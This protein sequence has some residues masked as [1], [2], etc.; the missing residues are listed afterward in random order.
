MFDTPQDRPRLMNHL[1]NPC[2]ITRDTRT[3]R[4][5]CLPYFHVL[6]A[7][8]CGTTDFHSRLVK[9]PDILNN[10]GGLGKETYYWCWTR[11]GL[12][13]RN[14]ILPHTFDDYLDMFRTPTKWILGNFTENPERQLITGDETPMDFWDFR[15]WYRDPQN[16]GLEEPRFLT[17][18]AMRHVYADPKFIILL[19][20]PAERT[21]SD[22]IFMG[23]G[24]TPEKFAKDVP[25]A[26]NTMAE[27]LREN[28]T[29]QCF[30]SD[31]MYHNMAMR[32]HISCYS[33][34]LREWL[35]V[36]QR[37]HFLVIR[38]ED[39]HSDMRGTYS[40]VFQFLDVAPPP[41]DVMAAM[42]D[43]HIVHETKKKKA[44]GDM[45]PHTRA[46]LDEFFVRF[47]Q[48]LAHLLQD[49]RFLWNDL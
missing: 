31:D 11:Y 7:D 2:F 38:S 37:K 24:Y 21:Y 49:D 47:N 22:Y 30:F 34:F 26:I 5:R 39:L 43:D 40:K 33:V 48:D 8:K 19:R 4:P 16:K 6:G 17:P 28:T 1:K 13:S 44:A 12:W 42:L 10:N 35:A 29:R 15:G 9:H 46:L 41:D 3:T 23:N 27:C 45:F 18:H 20:D 36:F 32:L 25:A 14:Y